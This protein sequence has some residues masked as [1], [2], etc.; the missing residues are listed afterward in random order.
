M[1]SA[2][3]TEG[4]SVPGLN[5]LIFTSLVIYLYVPLNLQNSHTDAVLREL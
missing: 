5:C 1:Y 2:L 4:V 3:W